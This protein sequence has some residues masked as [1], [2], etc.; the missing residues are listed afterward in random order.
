MV[1]SDTL[2]NMLYL[3][4][5]LIGGT[6][7][8]YIAVLFSS[9]RYLERFLFYFSSIYFLAPMTKHRLSIGHTFYV[10]KAAEEKEKP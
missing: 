5:F 2:R 7:K 1:L 10:A 3:F 9:T 8:I 4:S 6:A